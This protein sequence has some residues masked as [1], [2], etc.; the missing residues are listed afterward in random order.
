MAITTMREFVDAL[1]AITITGV[2]RQWTQGPPTQA[3][4]ADVPCSYVKLPNSS[5]GPLVL[6]NQG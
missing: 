6:Q 2:N 5:E 4:D 3:N 1:E